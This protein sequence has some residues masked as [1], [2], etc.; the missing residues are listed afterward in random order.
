MKRKGLII[1][2]A[3][4]ALVLSSVTGC[5]KY[6]QIRVTSGKIESL[7]MNGLRSVDLTLLVG[8]DNPA[9]KVT[10]KEAEG[11]LRHFGKIIGKV[12]LAPLVLMPRTHA[13]Y[14]V[15]AQVELAAGLGFKDLMRL[16]DPGKWDEYVVDLTFSGKASGVVV[17]K[18]IKD[19]PL[20]KLLESKTNEKV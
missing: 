12:T 4:L 14:T 3:V 9:G 17:K 2:T 1:L 15:E 7:N 11:T 10:V 18:S 19:I 13:E 6:E 20:K 5:R 8:I 16:A